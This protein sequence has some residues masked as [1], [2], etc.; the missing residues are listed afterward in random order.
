MKVGITGHQYLKD[1]KDWEWV[2]LELN[3]VLQKLPKPL[4]G[5][6][7]LAIGTD[8]LFARLLLEHDGSF[9]VVLPFPGY[10][11][12]LPPDERDEY[13]RLLKKASRVTTLQKQ[14]TD[15]ESYLE[16]GKRVVDLSD[17]LIA[18]WDGKPAKGLGGTA[19]VVEYAR[20]K[21]KP[22]MHL[23]PVRH[24]VDSSQHSTD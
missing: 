11:Q 23:D 9:D 18:V 6:T 19:D 7:C 17:L 4:I 15:E 16:A 24:V 14:G 2:R 5:L 22:I 13:R 20:Q 10:E 8:S 3:D 1:A 12:K 21:Q